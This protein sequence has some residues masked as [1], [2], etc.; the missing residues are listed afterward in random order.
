[1]GKFV[2]TKEDFV[3]EQCGTHV[4]GNGYTNHCHE[5]LWSKH[6]DEN[7]GDRAESCGG[8]MKPISLAKKKEKFS[9]T[10][11]CLQCGAE[12]RNI[13]AEGDNLEILLN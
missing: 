5:C 8:M 1:M 6:V 7:P 3:C 4:H 10:H 2:R 9:V 12:R 13:A 11:Q